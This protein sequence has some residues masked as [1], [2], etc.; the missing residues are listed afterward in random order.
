MSSIEDADRLQTEFDALPLPPAD[1]GGMVFCVAEGRGIAPAR[2][3]KSASGEAVVLFPVEKPSAPLPPI[4]LRHLSVL[5]AARCRVVGSEDEE[6]LYTVVQ[7]HGEDALRAY[8][9]SMVGA[10][11]KRRSD[12]PPTAND[13]QSSVR[14]LIELFRA[15]AQPA[16]RSLRGLWGEL[17]VLAISSDP[18]TL[19]E[20]WHITGDERFDFSLDSHRLEVKTGSRGSRRHHFSLDQLSAEGLQVCVISL[21]I[22]PAAGGLAL[23]DLIDLVTPKLRGPTAVARFV[24]TVANVLGSDWGDYRSRFDQVL[25]AA[26]VRFVAADDVPKVSLPLPLGVG[27]VEFVADLEHCP[28][29]TPMDLRRAGAL[30]E[31]AIPVASSPAPG[32]IR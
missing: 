23:T 14:A 1:R 6:R 16:T 5:F 12:Q 30:W 15:A 2:L 26:S 22:E 19:A 11:L 28:V 21:Q 20:G 27:Q 29:L 25:A 31:A 24:A 8:F 10:L 9:F 3:A 4:E 7:C 18:R 32:P 17:L 13:I